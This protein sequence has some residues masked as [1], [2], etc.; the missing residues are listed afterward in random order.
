MNN[1]SLKC[2]RLRKRFFKVLSVTALVLIFSG[3]G[4]T[5]SSIQTL[6]PDGSLE[7]TSREKELRQG[8]NYQVGV[9]LIR[10]GKLEEARSV[11]EVA[12]EEMPDRVEVRNALGALY[13]RLGLLEKAVSE[14]RKGLDLLKNSHQNGDSHVTASHVHNNLGIALR[15]LGDFKKAEAEYREAIRLNTRFSD[16]YYNI[17]VLYDLYM[18]QGVAAVKYYRE[19]VSLAGTNKNVELWIRDLE[20]NRNSPEKE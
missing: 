10:E 1:R 20:Q 4:T 3:C 16:P 17:G 9:S 14:Y 19:Y 5:S 13:R 2:L 15:Q 7:K 8:H 6:S 18:N 11:L 12:G